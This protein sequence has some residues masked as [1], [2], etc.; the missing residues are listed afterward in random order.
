MTG[1]LRVNGLR[2][3]DAVGRAGRGPGGGV[4]WPVQA[5]LEAALVPGAAVALVSGRAA[6]SRPDGAGSSGKTQLAVGLAGSL[7]QSRTVDLLAWVNAGS[8]AG[9]GWTGSGPESSSGG[10]WPATRM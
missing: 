10:S 2:W 3:S 7:W 6:A 4:T 8:R 1:S 9:H 5:G